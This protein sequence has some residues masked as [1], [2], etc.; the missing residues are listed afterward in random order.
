M[1]LHQLGVV[2]SKLLENGELSMKE[3]EIA[4]KIL[5]DLSGTLVI[6]A[7]SILSF[8][9]KAIQYSKVD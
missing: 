7:T 8:C 4:Q 5:K 1:E 3:M 2:E 9:S 6:R